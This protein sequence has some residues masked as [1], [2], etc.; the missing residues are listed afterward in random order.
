MTIYFEGDVFLYQTTDDGDI[1]VEA[2]VVQMS[3]GLE[4][5]A[6]ISLFGGNEDDNGQESNKKTW[7]GNIG[8]IDPDFRYRSETQN[9]LQSIPATVNNLKRIDD[10]ANRDLSWMINKK[11]ASEI[12]IETTIPTINAILITVKII[13]NGEESTFEFSENWKAEI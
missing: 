8:E 6:Y 10:A 11:V 12:L 1:N 5:A 13:A 7:W 2:G 3:G 9:L 4:T